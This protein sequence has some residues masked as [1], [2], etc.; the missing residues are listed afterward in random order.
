MAAL[1]KREIVNH[2]EAL[3][4]F[5]IDKIRATGPIT[6]AEYMKISASA[7]TIFGM[8]GDFITAPELTQIFGE[9]LGVWCYYEL[10]NT[11]HRGPWQLVECGPGTG[12]LMLDILSVMDNFKEKNLTVHLVERSDALM[13]EQEKLLCSNPSP[14]MKSVKNESGNAVMKNMSKSG[15]PIYWYKIIEDV[16]E[17]FSVFINNEFLDALPI[18]QFIRDSNGTWREVYI[19]INKVNELCFVK[20]NGENLHTRGLIPED[21]RYDNHRT[22]WECSPE[23]GTLINQVTERIVYNGGFGIFID[24]GHDGTR[25]ELSFRAYKKHKQVNPL[26]Q[27]G[28]TDLTADVNFGY[29]KSLVENRAAV[30]GPTTQRFRLSLAV[31]KL[32]HYSEFLVQLGAE[33]RLRMLLKSCNEQVKQD[34]LI[35][36]YNYL[37]GDMGERFLALAIFPKTLSAILEKRGGPAGFA[38]RCS[39]QKKDD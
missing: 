26:V 22:H 39:H 4:R 28:S 1:N 36:S 31:H 18:H 34:A 29:I 27:P 17:Q 20:S 11:G 13:L 9:L 30:Y 5:I 7:P 6:V 16:P 2:C 12:Q 32:K 14:I 24:Y 23:A 19:G 38:I 25:N 3:K 8:E 35:K 33:M 10:A 15:F 21:I 37:M